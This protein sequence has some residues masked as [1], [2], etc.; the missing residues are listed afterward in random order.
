MATINLNSVF[1]Y[2]VPKNKI[3]HELF[4]QSSANLIQVSLAFSNLIQSNDHIQR[5]ELVGDVQKL[6]QKGDDITHAIYHRLDSDFIIPFDRED[7]HALATVLDD[8]ADLINSAATRI[9]L[10]KVEHYSPAMQRIAEIISRQIKEIDIAIK[11]MESMKNIPRIKEAL[12][13]INSLEN[14][15][16]EI[17]DA[18]IATLF[19]IEDDAIR[20]LKTKEIL[21]DMETATDKCE[22]VA[23]I[24]ETIVIKL[25]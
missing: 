15:A 11:Y 12:V 3:F 5:T 4:C 2:L 7:I 22:D 24:I 23:N 14:E 13:K 25:S 19:E 17:L 8:V 16:D 9:A 21:E 18:A 20:I 6:E 10:Y 1:S